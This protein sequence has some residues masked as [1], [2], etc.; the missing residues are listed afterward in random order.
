VNL[1]FIELELDWP[2]ELSVFDL[3][4]YILSKLMKHGTPLRWAITSLTKD[5]GKSMQKISIEAVFLVTEDKRKD[6]TSYLN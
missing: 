6:I 3:R 2:A 4:T 5:G 1:D